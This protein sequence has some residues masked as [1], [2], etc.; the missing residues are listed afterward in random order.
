M[1]NPDTQQL[2]S[3]IG[4]TLHDTTGD[5]IGRIDDIYVDDETGQ[6]EWLAVTTGLFGSR[7]SFVPVRGATA[8][9][10]DVR[11]QWSKDQVKDAPHADPDGHLE[12]AEERALYQHYGIAFE[13]APAGGRDARATTDN[14]MT[15]SE[16]ELDVSKRTQEAGRVRLRK[17]VETEHVDRTVPVTREEVRIEREPITDGNVDKAMSGAEITEAEHEVVLHEDQVIVNTHV[18]PK[19]RVRLEKDTVVEEQQVGADLRKEH[20][21]VEGDATRTARR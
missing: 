9:G 17:W 1:T 21:E 19:E 16:E 7:V 2:T 13:G 20:V 8:V 12:P 3:W 15:R 18:E 6:P 4:R 5:K 11:C 10:D 14:A